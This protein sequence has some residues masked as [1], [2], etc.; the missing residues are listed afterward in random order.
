MEHW[1]LQDRRIESLM[2]ALYTDIEEGASAGRL[3]GESIGTALS[4]YLTQKFAVFRPK[5]ASYHGGI[6]SARHKRV[7][8]HIEAHL[9]E[10]ITL[11]ALAEISGMGTHYFCEL[12]KQSVHLSP[13]QYVVRRRVERAKSY[14]QDSHLP[15]IDASH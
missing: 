10:D 12:F 7:T 13:Y 9:D 2:L 4:V 1:N 8:E 3:Y 14:L 5:T 15:V 11:S 6:P